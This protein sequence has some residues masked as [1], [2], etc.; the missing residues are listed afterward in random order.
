MT[1]KNEDMAVQVASRDGPKAGRNNFEAVFKE[2][3]EGG[4]ME[5]RS[6]SGLCTAHSGSMSER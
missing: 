4:M 5:A 2:A 6:F 3:M 1:E